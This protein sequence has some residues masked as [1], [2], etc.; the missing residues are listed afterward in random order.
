[1]SDKLNIYQK[2]NL[3]ID[4]LKG[5]LPKTGKMTAGGNFEY[6]TI[7]DVHDALRPLFV[8]M[9]VSFEYSV[10]DSRTIEYTEPRFNKAT[11]GVVDAQRWHNEKLLRMRLVNCDDPMEFIEGVETGYGIDSQDKGPGK[12][13][14]Y[15]VK[16]WLINL[17]HLKGQPDLDA[18][19]VDV[20]FITPEQVIV[21]NDLLQATDGDIEK[22]L[23]WIQAPS[24]E[25][26]QA[27][28]YEKAESTLK[29]KLEGAK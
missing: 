24:I 15:A 2:K 10:E 8:D 26:I 27:S 19:V 28:Q 7:D 9:G 29:R 5:A 23:A 21:L 22:F 14:S 13:S 25:A 20:Q 6:H 11:G 17:F 4:R 12:A 1:M 3:I 16:T 18:Q